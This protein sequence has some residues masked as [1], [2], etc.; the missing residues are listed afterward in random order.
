MKL[1][2]KKI[3]I[4]LLVYILAVQLY[5]M[6]NAPIFYEAD[7]FLEMK[8]EMLSQEAEKY[9]TIFLGSSRIYRQLDAE[10]FDEFTEKETHSF[11]FGLPATS[12]PEIYF[13]AEK[14]LEDENFRPETLLLEVTPYATINRKNFGKVKTYYYLNWDY[15]KF[16]I[17]NILNP[18]WGVWKKLYNSFS[19]S[20]SVFYSLLDPSVK[21]SNSL[22]DY[23]KIGSTMRHGYLSLEQDV[24][25]GNTNFLVRKEK[26]LKN[27]KKLNFKVNV[28]LK[29]FEKPLKK[30]NVA[31]HSQKLNE[32]SQIC[33]DKG[34]EL[35]FMILPRYSEYVSVL[36][37]KENEKEFEFIE[38]ADGKKYPEF[39][40]TGY[41]FDAGHL[42]EKGAKLFS[43]KMA[44]QF[45]LI[46]R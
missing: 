9:N 38:L 28:A 16:S 32:L 8:N 23:E 40:Q 44:E 13:I 42:N 26:L 14:L 46:L 35:I 33:R 6:I 41:S 34:I 27:P 22:K 31:A 2:L 20:I 3:L 30:L 29:E 43:E 7:A 24:R 45:N 21:E 17:K 39:Y 10:K 12:N 15:L 36:N 1:F 5:K 11:N 18:D 25:E 4:F 37:I 19:L